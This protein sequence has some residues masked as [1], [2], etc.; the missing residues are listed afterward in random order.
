MK[1][2]LIVAMDQKGVIGRENSLPW[3]LSSDLKNF[4]KATMGKPVIMG[5][6][7]NE[8]IGK[9]LPGR[10]NIIITRNENYSS[11]DCIVC[12]NLDEAFDICAN[13]E[14]VVIIGGREIY[15]LGLEHAHR[16]YLTEV[17]ADVMGDVYFPLFDRNE[18]DEIDEQK[19]I[20][21]EENDYPFNCL[22]LEKK[23]PLYW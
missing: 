17:Q 20:A 18:W 16:I 23:D 22:I 4:K 8:S 9:S 2:S 10:K 11:S 6:K 21:D 14:E 3:H 19:F 12:H 5:R 15:Q 1:I 7:T 13:D